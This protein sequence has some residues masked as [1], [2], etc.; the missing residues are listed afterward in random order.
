MDNYD[1]AFDLVTKDPAERQMLR[2]RSNLMSDVNDWIRIEQLTQVQAAKIIGCDQPRI[3]ELK[4]G[5][6]S[7]FSLDWLTKAMIKLQA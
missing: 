5:R 4:N 7:K 1:S 2:L 3:S 6:L